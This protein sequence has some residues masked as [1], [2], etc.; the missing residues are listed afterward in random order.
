M[1]TLFLERTAGGLPIPGY[2][3]G[4]SG[5]VVLILGGVHG[6]EREG[7][8]LCLGLLDHLRRGPV[9]RVRATLIPALN[10]DGMLRGQRGNSAGVDLNRNLPTADWS[11]EIATP[12]YHPGPAAGSE[13]ESMA[14]TAWIATA[15]PRFIISLHSFRD[16]MVNV[17]GDCGHA[18]EA[19]S[20]RGGYRVSPTIGY[21]TPGCLGT[22]AGV[23]RG[24]PTITYE[25][26]RGMP[27]ADILN[28]HVP[29][30]LDALDVIATEVNP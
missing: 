19:L 25:L 27:T 20:R 29:A 30:L 28:T 23:E 12:R 24:I 9:P 10:V 16:P 2:I 13:P 17:N 11:P 14:L 26:L 8:E 1:N 7:I 4:E 5:P 18:A 6:D 22:Y 3:F 21:P 15:A